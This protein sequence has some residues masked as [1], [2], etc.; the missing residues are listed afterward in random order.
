MYAA[1]GDDYAHSL[2]PV[3][4]TPAAFL[5]ERHSHSRY[6]TIMEES[7]PSI[8]AR[9]MATCFIRTHQA[10]LQRAV[11]MDLNCNVQLQRSPRVFNGIVFRRIWR[12]K[13]KVCEFFCNSISICLEMQ[14]KKLYTHGMAYSRD[15]RLRVIKVYRRRPHVG[16]G[17]G[18][19]QSKY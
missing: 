12:Q 14:V 2:N 6:V 3:S 13:V 9:V 17:H 19:I 10:S 7:L 5:P 8:R 11:A 1:S 18:G 15:L 4:R 16:S